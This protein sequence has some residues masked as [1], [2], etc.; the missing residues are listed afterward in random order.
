MKTDF[1]VFSSYLKEETI[2]NNISEKASQCNMH[3]YKFRNYKAQPRIKLSSTSE[4]ARRSSFIGNHWWLTC[5]CSWEYNILVM[6]KHFWIAI[7]VMLT[8]LV[9]ALLYCL[10]NEKFVSLYILFLHWVVE[11]NQI[12]LHHKVIST[13]KYLSTFLNPKLT[14]LNS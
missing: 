8:S 10:M 1:L 13:V 4:R 2:Q 3:S 11:D 9:Q 6:F 14:N 7:S 5:K 12:K